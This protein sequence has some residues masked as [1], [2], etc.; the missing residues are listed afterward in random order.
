MMGLLRL[1]LCWLCALEFRKHAGVHFYKCSCVVLYSKS[2]TQM[3][4][5]VTFGARISKTLGFHVTLKL[6]VLFGNDD[7]GRAAVL[8]PEM[9]KDGVGII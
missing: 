1:A 2:A 9:I 8:H 4:S 5:I 6:E 3:D 7:V